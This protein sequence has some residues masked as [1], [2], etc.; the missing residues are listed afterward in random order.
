M[1]EI[2]LTEEEKQRLLINKY[3]KKE[4]KDIRMLAMLVGFAYLGQIFVPYAFGVLLVFLAPFFGGQEK[5]IELYSDGGFL[6]VLQTVLSL[7]SFTV[8][9]FIIGW[10]NPRGK[11]RKVLFGLPEKCTFT[12]LV[13]MG[14]GFCAFGNIATNSVATFFE[15]FG[16][17]FSS[18]EIDF[19]TGMTGFLLSFIAIVVTPAL[20]EEFAMRGMVMGGA[21]PFGKGFA[22]IVSAAIFGLMHGNFVQ[23]PFAFIVGIALAYAVIKSGSI[24]TAIFIHFI[25]NLMSLIMDYVFKTV[26]DHNI[27]GVII[28]VYFA[29]CFLCFFLGLVFS[30]RVEGFWHQ[31]KTERYLSLGE[32]LCNFF[33]SPVMI[34]AIIITIVMSL[35]YVSV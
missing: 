25:N 5:L 20:V 18:P 27:Q 10:C 17:T 35:S 28:S 23:I 34:V 21:R 19:P 8:P 7:L 31:E 4:K 6:M 26:T 30:R 9:Y 12:P 16:I 33:L 2:Y 13:L 1:E 22:I 3:R 29:V 24:W 11:Q 14:L 32:Q 15:T